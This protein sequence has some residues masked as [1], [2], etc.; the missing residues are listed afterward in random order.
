MIKYFQ[1][2]NHFRK[3]HVLRSDLHFSSNLFE[4]IGV[5]IFEQNERSFNKGFIGIKSAH[6]HFAA[7]NWIPNVLSIHFT[8]FEAKLRNPNNQPWNGL[9]YRFW[10]VLEFFE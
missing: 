9:S 2:I 5:K 8:R 10:K 1:A 7:F 4:Q 3:G 6:S